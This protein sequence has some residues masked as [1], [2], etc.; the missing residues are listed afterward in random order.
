MN[1]LVKSLHFIIYHKVNK[2]LDNISID[3]NINREELN[4]YMQEQEEC[5]EIVNN[6]DN[7]NDIIVI[8]ILSDDENTET[9]SNKEKS[10]INCDIVSNTIVNIKCKQ[11]TR[12]GKQC[13]YNAKPNSEYC[14]RHSK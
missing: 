6:N 8:P 7:D 4:K 5:G 1:E 9:E 11:V 10:D 13:D 2:V 12:K 14:G 3:F